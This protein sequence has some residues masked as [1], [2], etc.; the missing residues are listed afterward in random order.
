MET[1]IILWIIIAT[2]VGSLPVVLIKR[3]TETKELFLLFVCIVL[4]IVLIIAY[5]NIFKISSISTVYPLIKILSSIIVII[6]G[7]LFF[8]EVL[9]IEKYFGILFALFSIYLLSI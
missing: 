4:Y 6:L 2:I 9:S 5:L 8:K 1:K 3:Y 7:I